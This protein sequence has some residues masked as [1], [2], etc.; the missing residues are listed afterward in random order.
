MD[1]DDTVGEKCEFKVYRHIKKKDG[2]IA[3]KVV[4]NAFESLTFGD[5]DTPYALVINRYLSE[6]NQLEKISLQIN[7]RHILKVFREVIGSYPTVPFDFSSSF[8]LESPFQM[9]FHHWDDLDQRRQSTEDV[10]ERMH[11]NLLFDFME[12]E[13]GHDRS[14]MQAMVRNKQIK[15]LSLW[16]IFRPGDLVFQEFLGHPWLLRCERTAYEESKVTGPYFEVHCV[17]TDHDGILAGETK[18]VI[19]IF[20]KRSFAA[21]NPANITDLPVYP[22][23]FVEERDELEVRVRERGRKFL[24]LN[25][26]SIQQYDGQAQFL[27]EPSFDYWNPEMAGFEG[28]WLPHAEL[29]RVIV[30]RKTFQED[31][32]SNGT[33]V[34]STEP[35]PLLC[36]PYEFGYSLSR[37]E[38]GRYLVDQMRPVEWKEDVWNSL[39]I[40]DRQKLVLQSLVNSHKFPGDARDQSLQKGRGLVILLHGTPGSGKTL[41][42]ET[43]AEGTQRALIMTSLGELNK[44]DNPYDFEYRLKM[45]LQYATQWEA[46][47]LM[48]EADVFLEARDNSGDN[49]ARNALVAVFLKALEYF[50]GIVFLTTNRITSFDRAMKSRIHLALEYTPP[51]IETRQQLWM[52]ILKSI[53]AHEIDLDPEDAVNTFVSEKM[54]GREI[55]N[56]IHTARTIARFQKK[57]LEIAHIDTVLD[58]W[59]E[60]EN[61]LK[62]ASSKG[63][64]DKGLMMIG[65]TNSIVHEENADFRS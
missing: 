24:A 62:K 30:D 56:A 18:T 35:D 53:P 44:W 32:Y 63:P 28:V 27:K 58:V 26:V 49:A 15:Y 3:V 13:I 29:G 33:R 21:E 43:A 25:E 50:S 2:E 22:R 47:V 17:Y 65:R 16:C 12:H 10:E 23:M 45:L 54:N 61:S 42:A 40:G 59:R 4:T 6:K 1:S 51:R 9:L 38:W 7:S 5:E 60:F 46:V 41:T 14:V 20:Q 31:Q 52:Q 39:I 34:N 57:P 55:A 48:D 19:N 37:K 8:T 11:L 36:P 64:G